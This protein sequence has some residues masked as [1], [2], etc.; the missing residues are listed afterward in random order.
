MTKS[1]RTWPPLAQTPK[2]G[3]PWRFWRIAALIDG[4]VIRTWPPLATYGAREVGGETVAEDRKARTP[5]ALAD[6]LRGG[7]ENE[8]KAEDGPDFA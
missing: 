5:A 8:P 2:N 6:Y 4:Q 3:T 7:S 1:M